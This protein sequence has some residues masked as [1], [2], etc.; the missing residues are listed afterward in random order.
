M[1]EQEYITVEIARERLGISHREMSLLL[2][3]EALRHRRDQ[4]DGTI[5]WVNSVDVNDAVEYLT[6]YRQEAKVRILQLITTQGK[7]NERAAN[8]ISY[9]A[10]SDT[11]LMMLLLAAVSYFD[12]ERDIYFGAFDERGRIDKNVSAIMK[13]YNRLERESKA[14]RPMSEVVLE[15]H[16]QQP[17]HKARNEVF[18]YLIHKAREKTEQD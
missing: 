17:D 14:G 8:D 1:D 9:F 12:V 2:E 3:A 13:L 7:A 15:L 5:R 4:Q 11:D 10:F 18:M 6:H 16:E